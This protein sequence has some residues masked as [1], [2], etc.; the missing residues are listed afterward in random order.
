MTVQIGIEFTSIK[1]KIP[2]GR[3]GDWIVEKFVVPKKSLE[4]SKC[5][6]VGRDVPPGEYTRLVYRGWDTVMSDTPA[7][8]KDHL[9]FFWKVED[10]GTDILMNGLGLGIALQAVLL[11]DI[12]S[13][14]VIEKSID[15][16]SLVF[17]YF[18]DQRIRII[19]EDAFE[20]NPPKGMKYSHVWHDIW[21]NICS[22]N[23][24]EMKKLK[25]KYARKTKWQ[26]Y[27][28]E[29]ECRRINKYGR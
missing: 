18:D 2:S 21:T 26:G 11:C 13:V 25:C 19:H 15:V 23:L 28:C 17:P 5:A 3:S 9:P 7:E 16:I 1:S 6:M 10:C 24:P 22:D 4:G 14:T 8:V 27:W 12:K 20:Y 29:Y